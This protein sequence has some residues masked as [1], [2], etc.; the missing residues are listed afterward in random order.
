M[1]RDEE[2]T[3]SALTGEAMMTSDHDVVF[4]TAVVGIAVDN[5]IFVDAYSLSRTR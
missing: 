3:V 1:D 2:D 4:C 5:G